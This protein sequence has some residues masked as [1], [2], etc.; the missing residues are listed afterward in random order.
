MAIDTNP[1]TTNFLQPFSRFFLER[2]KALMC[3]HWYAERKHFANFML[4][5][6][7]NLILCLVVEEWTALNKFKRKL[8]RQEKSSYRKN[9][10]FQIF[11]LRFKKK[12]R[13][14]EK[15]EFK[16]IIRM[17]E[18]NEGT[19]WY[20]FIGSGYG[21]KVCYL[22]GIQQKWLHNRSIR[23]NKCPDFKRAAQQKKVWPKILKETHN[24]K[25]KCGLSPQL[26]RC[27]CK[28][29]SLTFSWKPVIYLRKTTNTHHNL[30]YQM[31]FAE[32]Q[33]SIF[34]SC[35]LHTS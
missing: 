4:L 32:S 23:E 27:T 30:F 25:K 8:W 18:S 21:A 19:F 17:E 34:F 22:S 11:V 29:H 33:N 26:V 2:R 1:M 12:M 3:N 10:W 7:R 28:Q 9:E 24:N 6:C 15:G 35:L 14:V 5:F 20:M 31:D 13:R 16:W